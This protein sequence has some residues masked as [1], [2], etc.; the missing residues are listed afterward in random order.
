MKV[1]GTKDGI[2]AFSMGKPCDPPLLD[3]KATMT[4]PEGAE[5]LN[6]WELGWMEASEAAMK[7]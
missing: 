2:D 4:F 3:V 5:Y 6:A 1:R 7:G